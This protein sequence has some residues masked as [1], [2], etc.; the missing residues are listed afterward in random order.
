MNSIE[1]ASLGVNSFPFC[2]IKYL[3]FL[4]ISYSD[5]DDGKDLPSFFKF[6]NFLQMIHLFLLLMLVFT[7]LPFYSW[8]LSVNCYVT[9]DGSSFSYFVLLESI[10][11]QS[12]F[13]C[14][15]F[16][17]FKQADKR[18]SFVSWLDMVIIKSTQKKQADECFILKLYL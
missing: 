2:N 14:C 5:H 6:G 7:N 9:C 13:Y 18:L 12:F 1:A 11:R 17:V 16:G 15:E 8:L 3:M 10:S 4:C